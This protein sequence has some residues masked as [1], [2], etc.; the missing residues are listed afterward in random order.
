[1]PT[2]LKFCKFSLEKY[3]DAD[4]WDKSFEEVGEEEKELMPLVEK[5][6]DS[7]SYIDY[8]YLASILIG[9]RLINCSAVAVVLKAYLKELTAAEV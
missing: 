6:A 9:E 8:D 3:F 5:M 7:F 2:I 4:A 1:M